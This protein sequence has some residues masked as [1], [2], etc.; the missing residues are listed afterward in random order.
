MQSI[1]Q[2]LHLDLRLLVPQISLDLEDGAATNVHLVGVGVRLDIE[3]RAPEVEVGA[4][5]EEALAESDEDRH[6]EDG[7]RVEIVEL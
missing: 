5:A 2:I 4:N 1:L 6:V 3:Q 7:V